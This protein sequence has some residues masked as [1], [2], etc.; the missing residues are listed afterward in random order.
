MDNIIKNNHNNTYMNFSRT[1]Q[2]SNWEKEKN[3]NSTSGRSTH[4]AYSQNKSTQAQSISALIETPFFQ[5]HDSPQ[6]EPCFLSWNFSNTDK[7]VILDKLRLSQIGDVDRDNEEVEIEVSTMNKTMSLGHFIYTRS[8]GINEKNIKL[9]LPCHQQITIKLIERDVCNDDHTELTVFCRPED[10]ALFLSKTIDINPH[11]TMTNYASCMT[12]PRETKVCHSLGV[13][14]NLS[15]GLT[16]TD[17]NTD[18]ISYTWNIKEC[19][20]PGMMEE[21]STYE[22]VYHIVTRNSS[23]ISADGLGSDLYTCYPY[24]SSPACVNPSYKAKPKH[25]NGDPPFILEYIMII[26]GIITTPIFI[27]LL[28]GRLRMRC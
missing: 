18:C 22:L 21:H 4:S 10:L 17:Q 2:P 9:S 19:G 24:Q 6:K 1:T 12:N 8:G 28:F 15:E 23:S 5:L 16:A 7:L 20:T 13:D 14:F 11:K 3:I 27:I 26:S 25:K